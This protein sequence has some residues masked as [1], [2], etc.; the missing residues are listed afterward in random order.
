MHDMN[1]KSLAAQDNML[2]PSRLK[3]SSVNAIDSLTGTMINPYSSSN[4][5]LTDSKMKSLANHVDTTS[6]EFQGVFGDYQRENQTNL[7]VKHL[8][9]SQIELKGYL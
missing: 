4:N 7:E 1:N 3:S 6:L 8:P 5:R 9:F 2:S